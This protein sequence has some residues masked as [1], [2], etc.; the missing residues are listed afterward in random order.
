MRAVLVCGARRLDLGG[1]ALLELAVLRGLADKG[2]VDGNLEGEPRGSGPCCR[3]AAGALKQ[4]GTPPHP[5]PTPT[6]PPPHTH[7]DPTTPHRPP[8][9][10]RPPHPFC[11]HT[12]PFL[13]P[14]RTSS[15]AEFVFIASRSAISPATCSELRRRSSRVRWA[16]P[17]MAPASAMPPSCPSWAFARP[18]VCRLRFRSSAALSASTPPTPTAFP[19]KSRMRRDG[20]SERTDATAAAPGA[21]RRSERSVGPPTVCDSATVP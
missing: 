9:P 6:D 10:P 12:L 7:T 21:A 20:C 16:F 1:E 11:G 3:G 5:R 13:P 14:R 15:S 2:R 18:R 17:S 8:R 19:P 4:R